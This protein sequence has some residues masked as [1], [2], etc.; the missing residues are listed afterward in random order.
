MQSKKI[1]TA[2]LCTLL[3]LILGWGL[4]HFIPRLLGEP[5]STTDVHFVSELGST[6]EAERDLV[7]KLSSS[8]ELR[9]TSELDSITETE[10]VPDGELQVAWED[11]LSSRVYEAETFTAP[12]SE[13]TYDTME[14]MSE[15]M[16][17]ADARE[18]QALAMGEL[19]IEDIKP[20]LKGESKDSIAFQQQLDARVNRF[21]AALDE[22]YVRY[23]FIQHPTGDVLAHTF[24]S[25]L[26]PT[27]LT[28]LHPIDGEHHCTTFKTFSDGIYY[29]CALPVMLR[30]DWSFIVRVG[31]DGKE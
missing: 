11:R 10:T 31:I 23:F 22:R 3:L 15:N 29:D 21:Y 8:T 20:L 14:Q 12:E 19:L 27:W 30:D 13:G 24:E 18:R 2:A 28:T 4:W 1:F 9:S 16:A 17:R 5:T 7:G 25:S 6:T 26:L